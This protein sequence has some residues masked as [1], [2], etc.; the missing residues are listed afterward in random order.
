MDPLSIIAS[1]IALAGAAST[2]LHKAREFFGAK[3]ELLCLINE[4]SDIRLVVEEFDHLMRQRGSNAELAK[5]SI[6]AIATVLQIAQADSVTLNEVNYNEVSR[7]DQSTGQQKVR[8]FAW[9][10]H[11]SKLVRLQTRLKDTRTT[12]VMLCSSTT[13]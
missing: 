8:R 2:S 4:V 6:D 5:E 11:K 7:V 9:T 12:L 13:L 10:R 3:T 1:A